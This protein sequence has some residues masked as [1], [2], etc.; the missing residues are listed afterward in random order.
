M[1]SRTG[2]GNQLY[3][4]HAVQSRISRWFQPRS[5]IP[6]SSSPSPSHLSAK[7]ASPPPRPSPRYSTCRPQTQPQRP[8]ATICSASTPPTGP[9]PPSWPTTA[10]PPSRSLKTTRS[11][12][13]FHTNS[14]VSLAPKAILSTPSSPL[15]IHPSIHQITSSHNPNV[16]LSLPLSPKTNLS[17]SS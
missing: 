2:H 8:H 7:P 1:T 13:T 9:R 14:P 3:Q 4:I 11:T 15:R 16:S 17:Q 10:T 12:G 6:S 5:H